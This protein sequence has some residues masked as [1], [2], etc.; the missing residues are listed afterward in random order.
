MDIGEEGFLSDERKFLM[1]RLHNAL[2]EAMGSGNMPLDEYSALWLSDID[3]LQELVEA[4]EEGRPASIFGTISGRFIIPWLTRHRGAGS[5]LNSPLSTTPTPGVPALP[6]S[7]CTPHA[8]APHT[9]TQGS[10]SNQPAASTP[11]RPGLPKRSASG[12]LVQK[13]KANWSEAAKRWA[14]RRDKE[15]CVL[16]GAGRPIELAHI[17]PISMDRFIDNKCFWAGLKVYWKADRVEKWKNAL[18]TEKSTEVCQN[19]ICMCP[20]AHAYWG[21]AYFALKVINVSDDKKSMTVKFFWL[22][23]GKRNARATLDTTPEMPTDLDSIN[24]AKLYSTSNDQV[25]KSGT[26]IEITTDDPRKKPLPSKELLDMQW[27]LHNLA[28]MSGAAGEID[29]TYHPEDS[30]DDYQYTILGYQK[31]NEYDEYYDN[32]YTYHS[33]DSFASEVTER[34]TPLAKAQDQANN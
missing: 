10:P 24:K 19:L 17:Y 16:T 34:L 23:R 15:S 6:T 26:S 22:K 1:Q 18:F 29:H 28:A 32:E 25:I 9:P 3:C 8:S 33:D 4:A 30:D 21:K 2:V 5:V 31:R 14:A 13:S 11:Q 12:R 7:T 27:V 20:N